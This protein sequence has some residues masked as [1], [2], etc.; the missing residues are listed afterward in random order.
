MDMSVRH[1]TDWSLGADLEILGKAVG[2]LATH[3]GAY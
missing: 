3:A 2:P 1:E